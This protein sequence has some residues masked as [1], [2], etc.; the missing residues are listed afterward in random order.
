MFLTD[1][2]IVTSSVEVAVAVVE[3]VEVGW[4]TAVA[5]AA[6][7]PHRTTSPAESLEVPCSTARRQRRQLTSR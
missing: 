1:A 2:E 4:R 5:D 6:A 3:S 7:A